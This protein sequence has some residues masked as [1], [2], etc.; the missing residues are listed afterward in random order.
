MMISLK[1]VSKGP[2]DDISVLVK[3]MARRWPGDKPLSEPMMVNLLTH[4][5]AT[6]PQWVNTRFCVFVFFCKPNKVV[7]I[8]KTSGYLT[9]QTNSM[10]NNHI[11]RSLIVETKIKIRYEIV[12]KQPISIIST[13]FD[14]YKR[15]LL[16]CYFTYLYI[17]QILLTIRKRK[18]ITYYVAA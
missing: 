8:T 10:N 1:C 7:S 16:P 9:S 6:P 5:C 12:I 14:N 15:F 13:D 17:L 11:K 2:I 18:C 3:I 4:I